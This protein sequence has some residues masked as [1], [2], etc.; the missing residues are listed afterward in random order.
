MASLKTTLGPIE[1]ENP[2]CVGSGTYGYGEEYEDFLDPGRLGA[3]FTKAITLQPRGG[4][5]PP[6]L[7]ETP[8]GMLN[9]IGLENPGLEYFLE[10]DA[11]RLS[12]YACRIIVNINGETVDEYAE[13]AGELNSCE[14]IDGIELNAS[15]PNVERGGMEFGIEPA[16]LFDLTFAV[17]GKTTLP[18]IVKLTPNV[19]DIV[20]IAQAAVEG[21]ADILHICNTFLGMAIDTDTHRSR[22]GRDYGGLSGPAIRPLALRL[23]HRAAMNVETPIIGGG[24]I[25]ETRDAIEFLIAGASAVSIGTVNYTHP[26]RSLEIIDGIASYLDERHLNLRDIIGSYRSCKD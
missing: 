18:L 12:K 15:C 26:R 21:G 2:V 20:P 11:P 6:R 4:N 1:L 14:H 7:C 10:N 13:L 24:G 25:W 8:S 23:V 17:R 3:L 19:G 22:L 9:S 5:P 16:A